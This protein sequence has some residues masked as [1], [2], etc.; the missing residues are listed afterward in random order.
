MVGA[1]CYLHRKGIVHRDIKPQNI[2]IDKNR[3]QL[4]DFGFAIKETDIIQ[5]KYKIGSPLYMSPEALFKK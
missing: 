5:A 2:L 4:G 3:P 1:V